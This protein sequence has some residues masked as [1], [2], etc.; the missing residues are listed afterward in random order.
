[1]KRP[2]GGCRRSALRAWRPTQAARPADARATAAKPAQ[3]G[4]RCLWGERFMGAIGWN[5][6]QIMRAIRRLDVGRGCG[7]A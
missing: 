6:S 5:F 1:M 7:L 2:V 3:P 4:R